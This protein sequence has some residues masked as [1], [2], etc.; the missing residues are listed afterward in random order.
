MADRIVVAY[1]GDRAALDALVRSA[2]NDRAQVIAVTLDLGGT[3]PLVG[4]RDDALAAGAVR[5]HAMDVRDAFASGVI[6][7]GLRAAASADARGELRPLAADF[8]REALYNI[9][10]LEAPAQIVEPSGVPLPWTAKPRRQSVLGG[11]LADIT[12]AH[13][14][15]VSV[16][17]IPMTIT[18]VLES[19]ETI[20]GEAAIDVLHLAYAELNGAADGSVVLAIRDGRV[21][22]ASAV[23]VS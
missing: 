22:V 12:F 10:R 6:V 14:S 13:G 23:A 4:L 3:M 8:V 1:F 16:N 21:A 15:P 2:S 20:T 7:P 17:G 5:C 19:I 9:A 11:A 18:E